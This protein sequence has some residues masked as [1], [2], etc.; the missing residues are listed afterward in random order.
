[1]IHGDGMPPE[2]ASIAI[3]GAGLSGRAAFRLARSLGYQAE[4]FDQKASDARAVFNAELVQRFA[5]CII[6]PGFSAEH[7]WRQV[8]ETS[9][10]ICFGELGFAA[11]H[12]KGRL[13]AVTGTN[14][15]TSTTELFQQACQAAGLTA[16]A[17]GN[18]GAPLSEAVLSS[19]NNEAAIAICE[20]SSF[21]AEL[22]R[23]LQLDALLWLNF[24]ED[25]LDRYP[26]MEAYFSA[27][28][29]LLECL[30]SKAPAILPE[31]IRRYVSHRFDSSQD[32][33]YPEAVESDTKLDSESPFAK[34]PFSQNFSLLKA[35][36]SQ[37]GLP[38]RSLISAANNS[39]LPAHRLQ[40]VRA[41]NQLS[42]WDDS[43]AT[44]FAACLAALAALAPKPIVWIGGGASK[45]GDL[46]KFVEQLAPYV[47]QAFVYGE[48]APLLQAGLFQQ[49]VGCSQFADFSSAVEAA[50][51]FC[52][53]HN[54]D[55][56]AWQL[57]LSPG[58][59]SL[60]QFASY[61]ERGKCYQSIVLSLMPTENQA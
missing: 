20:M 19:H 18:N 13:Y 4:L 8:A 53:K 14:G 3:L 51:G 50:V 21:Q 46:D 34:Q 25:H 41:S 10:K 15:K 24:A 52:K 23:G 58:F 38:E 54:S 12:W 17:L 5:A 28:A 29:N 1:M 33:I 60:D 7:P 43:K 16:L 37:L 61:A 39:R 35:L 42:V 22:P 40:L 26:Q 56:Q 44:N 55:A 48:V 30:K 47:R 32:F 49:A 45:G 6:S 57:L 11:Q 9:G 31:S 27:K 2:G 59:S 36:W